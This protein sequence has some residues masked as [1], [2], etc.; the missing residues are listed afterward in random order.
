NQS[1]TEGDPDKRKAILREAEQIMM[2]EMP[3]MPIYFYTHTWVKNDKVKG[4]F[5]DGLGAID[6]KWTSIE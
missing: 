6:W 5:Q 2:D 3:I 1:A 4:V